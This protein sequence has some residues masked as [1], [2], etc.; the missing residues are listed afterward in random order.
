[1]FR[2]LIL[3]GFI[4]FTAVGLAIGGPAWP[5][6]GA[7]ELPEGVDPEPLF[8]GLPALRVM[9]QEPAWLAVGS[10]AG[11]LMV[12]MGGVGVV[13]ITLYGAGLLFA[14]GQLAVGIMAAGQ[15]G[16]GLLL[17]LG[18]A[19]GALLSAGQ[20]VGGGLVWGQGQ[21]GWDGEKF[22][23]M[24]HEDLTDLFSFK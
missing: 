8:W 6:A 24:L 14:T 21:L 16:L 11:V 1:V 13:A 7:A 10:G 19:G 9:S 4:V 20:V 3:L 22:F 23:T 15:V 18:Q 5:D 2:F 17:W 12:G